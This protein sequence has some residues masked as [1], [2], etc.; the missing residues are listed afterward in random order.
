MNSGRKVQQPIFLL[1][2]PRSGTTMLGQLLAAHPQVA[3]W[4]EPRPIWSLGN[5]YLPDDVLDESHCR[6]AVARKIDQHFHQFLERSHRN[7]FMEKTP[8]NTLRVRFLQALY[9]DCRIIHIYR[10]GRAVV[11]SSLKMLQTPPAKGRILA[12]LRETPIES[13]PALA[14]LFYRDVIM[15]RLRGGQKPY[16]GPRPPQWRDWLDLP[17]A[18]MLARQWKALVTQARADLAALPASNWIECRYEDL[19]QR[20]AE[21]L[22]EL[23]AFAGLPP[24]TGVMELAHQIINPERIDAWKDLMDAEMQS[25][26]E[27]EL[28]PLLAELGYLP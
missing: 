9:P 15:R 26:I 24:E 25:L 28:E 13:W 8:S 14:M 22:P 7:R 17:P 18:L 1:G 20:P 21:V 23:L 12:R 16:W 5:A 11:A 10:D 19:L 3:Y 4:E 2:S 27:P 6:P